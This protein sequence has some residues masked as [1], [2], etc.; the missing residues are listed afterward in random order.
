[1]S[2]N[3]NLH[4]DTDMSTTMNINTDIKIGMNMTMDMDTNMNTKP[5]EHEDTDNTRKTIYK[6]TKHD[7]R[8]KAA[9]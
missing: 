9:A 4:M 6:L 1:M 3:P 8:S 5:F 7:P 2:G